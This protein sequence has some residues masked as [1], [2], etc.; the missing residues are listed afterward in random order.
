M[1]R[2][3]RAPLS[4]PPVPPPQA[5]TGGLRAAWE[6]ACP[7]PRAGGDPYLDW[8]LATQWQ[9]FVGAPRWIP[10]I[11]P[12]GPAWQ[13]VLTREG[14]RVRACPLGPGDAKWGVLWVQAERVAEVGAALPRCELSQPVPVRFEKARPPSRPGRSGQGRHI[15]V[16]LGS[17]DRGGAFLNQVF[18]AP[19]Q[20]GR[21]R[22]L[23][24]WDQETLPPKSG[25][26]PWKVPPAGYGRELDQAT[27]SR[28]QRRSAGDPRQ[29]AAL[30]RALDLPDLLAAAAREQADH[31]THVLD[32]LAGLPALRRNPANAKPS[33]MD[34]AAV[35]PMVLVSV[36]SSL[37]GQTTGAAGVAH[38]LAALQ[39]ILAEAQ[40][41]AP[42]AAVLVNISLGALAGPQD[43]SSALE[44]AIDALMRRQ[45]R[46]LVV[47]A[48]GN[49]GGDLLSDPSSG[50]NAGGALAPGASARLSWRLQ[51]Q[52]PTD[53]FLEIWCAGQ[54]QKAGAALEMRVL[55]PFASPWLK[56]GA[57]QDLRADGRLL[58]R[59]QLQSRPGGGCRA[60]LS[61]APIAG[62]RGGLPAGRWL[63]ELRNAGTHELAV[64]VRVQGDVPRWTD[65]APV[66]SVLADAQ[67]LL[68]GGAGS[69]NG[70]ATG[71]LPLRVSA[72]HADDQRDA[73]YTARNKPAGR[74]HTLVRAV[75]DEAPLTDGLL[76]AGVFSGSQVC[77][78]GTSVAAPVAARLW[79]DRLAA[80]GLPASP[81][82]WLVFLTGQDAHTAAARA[83]PHGTPPADAVASTRS[84]A[85]LRP[86]RG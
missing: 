3:A 77:M 85:P 78:S 69:M 51:P 73:I 75:A 42:Q 48:A 34:A 9:G 64:E 17:I 84:A 60:Q 63:L 10:L 20:S 15:P 62:P 70:L 76:A 21:C 61:L 57:M 49:H 53:S 2:A 6:A 35:A 83:W 12:R 55:E 58:G 43:G 32:T 4:S 79:A 40:A 29:E 54:P 45:P 37:A 47:F 1:K 33:V 80:G 24:F 56:T 8:A 31:A 59:M 30:Y 26:S 72:A 28:L 44:Q 81:A 86:A 22:I 67:G 41:V 14:E 16:V 39:H 13:R 82:S 11:A 50:T 36:P 19:G 5:S 18:C 52:D 46:L 74:R 68:L 23:S 38:I 25:R 7:G 65:P 27:L 71:R 66:Q